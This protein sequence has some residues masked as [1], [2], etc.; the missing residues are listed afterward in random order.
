MTMIPPQSTNR[1]SADPPMD[2]SKLPGAALCLIHAAAFKSQ[3]GWRYRA[4]NQTADAARFRST[5]RA[6]RGAA[7]LPEEV[8]LVGEM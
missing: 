7:M 4:M 8:V 1:S 3:T 6:W 2:F 5:C